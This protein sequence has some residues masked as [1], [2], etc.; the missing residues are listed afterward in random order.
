M[1]T[2]ILFWLL[3]ID[4]FLFEFDDKIYDKFHDI[5]LAISRSGASTIFE[6]AEL[7][8]PFIAVPLPN[9]K[10]NHQY[11]NAKYYYDKDCCWIID[12]KKFDKK[13]YIDYKLDEAIKQF[14]NTNRR[15][16]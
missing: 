10:D 3:N 2:L 12:Q 6:L 9:S 11:E 14:K 15:T 7:K 5:D 8:I 4:N 16:L 1:P 13:I